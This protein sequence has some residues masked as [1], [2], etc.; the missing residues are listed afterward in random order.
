MKA[1]KWDKGE[2]WFI[3]QEDSWDLGT[4]HEDKTYS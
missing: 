2:D 3:D 1:F 4:K